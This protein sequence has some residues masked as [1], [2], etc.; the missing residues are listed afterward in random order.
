MTA[1]D[2]KGPVN[3]GKAI[4]PSANNAKPVELTPSNQ[5]VADVAK[6]S[7][8]KVGFGVI[9]GLGGVTAIGFGA[10]ILL[11]T[12]LGLAAACAAAPLGAVLVVAGAILLI[13]A[14][15][16]ICKS[17]KQAPDLAQK[18]EH[19]L[20]VAEPS[21]AAREAD[22]VD[23][24][25]VDDAREEE[26]VDNRRA[27]EQDEELEQSPEAQQDAKVAAELQSGDAVIRGIQ[28]KYE[29]V[30]PK[31][32]NNMAKRIAAGQ[33][34]GKGGY[35]QEP[36]TLLEIFAK[37]YQTN[38]QLEGLKGKNEKLDTI[39][40]ELLAEIET[41]GNAVLEEQKPAKDKIPGCLKVKDLDGLK[42]YIRSRAKSQPA[43]A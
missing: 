16:L 30:P 12:G 25:Q 6:R 8:G 13:V 34:E 23:D 20:L 42:E 22:E 37:I 26:E 40:D 29:K 5:K 32:L 2:N 33:K 7:W 17:K 36:A 10:K 9:V 11:A 24:A 15:I 1:V 4:D 18:N 28:A 39:C 31:I 19:S 43:S 27:G 14:A 21:A 3:L 41:Y 38:A 35:Y